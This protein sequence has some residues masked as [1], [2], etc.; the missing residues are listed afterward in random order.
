M[1]LH[2]PSSQEKGPEASGLTPSFMGCGTLAGYI[3]SEP[4]L[5]GGAINSPHQAVVRIQ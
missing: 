1:Y 5:S 2:E 3:A 4:G